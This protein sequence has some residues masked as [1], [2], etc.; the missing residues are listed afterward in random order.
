MPN[1]IL[2]KRGTSIPG[3]AS[4]LTGELAI[5]TATGDV[6][7]KTDG[8]SV[9]SIS[10]TA[11][12]GKA[13]L[14]GATFTGKINTPASTTATAFLNLPHGSQPNTP[15]NGDLFTTTFD[16]GCR[17]NGTTRYFAQKS[18]SN[19]F[20]AGQK[21]TVSHS[22]TTAG[23]NVGPVAGDPSSL[24]NGDVWHN[25]TTFKLSARINGATQNLATEAYVTSAVPAYAT[26]AQAR[27]ITSTTTVMSPNRAAWLQMSPDFISIYRAG[28][29]A[30][31]TG[32]V[33]FQAG[34]VTT[35][36]A[37]SASSSHVL[38]TFG[39][40]QIDQTQTMTTRE[41]SVS[42]TN[43]NKVWWCAGR[44]SLSTTTT[45]GITWGFYCGKAEADANGDLARA[46][47]GWK[48]SSGTSP[49]YLVLQVH[50][51]T[52]LTNVTSTYAILADA[53]GDFP[54]FD[55]DII[56]EANGTTTLYVNGNSVATT[57]AGP[58]GASYASVCVWR[59]EIVCGAGVSG[60]FV[61]SRSK[62]A[63]INF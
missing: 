7:T 41:R 42:Y 47:F 50:N 39:A 52:T 8:G 16:L 2:H 34:A 17:I 6:F 18:N 22:S 62:F 58:A 14:A 12:A 59:E 1:T 21:Q 11:L 4:L 56:K 5:N 51:G 53:G 27:S 44:T 28:M 23:L 61:N 37:V 15:V 20:T 57:A 45:A 55:W 30:T 26:T 3:A 13:S 36:A 33:T 63:T 35:R 32:T 29:T 9:V 40:S 19:T 43:F 24:A 25:G 54:F 31:N 48:V 38:R 49:Q 46:G 60:G 10:P